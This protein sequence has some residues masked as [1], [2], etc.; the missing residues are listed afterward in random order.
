MSDDQLPAAPPSPEPTTPAPDP[1]HAILPKV[2]FFEELKRRNLGRV[3]TLYAAVGYLILEVVEVFAHLLHFPYWIGRS[4][5]LLMVVGFPVALLVAW[6]YEITPTGLKPTEEVSPRQSIRAETGKRLDRSIIAVLAIALC[7]LVV[8]KFWF[9]GSAVVEETAKPAERTKASTKVV[10]SSGAP[11]NIPAL[12]GVSDNSI[13]VLPFVNLSAETEQEYF[14]DGISEELLNRLAK[15]PGLRVISRS[16]AFS[17]KGKGAKIAQIASELNATH[18]LEGSVRK[19]GTQVRITAQLI[20]ARSDTNRWSETYD[21]PL[22]DIFAVQDEIATAIVAQFKTIMFQASGRVD[23]ATDPAAY[24]DYLRAKQL[25]RTGSK[26]T[27]EQATALL[28]Q[29]IAIDARYAPAWRLLSETYSQRSWL[30]FLP[31][32]EGFAKARAAIQQAI[33]IDPS[34]VATIAA[35]ADLV[36]HY[37]MNLPETARLVKRAL[38]LSPSHEAALSAAGNLTRATGDAKRSIAIAE[39]LVRRDPRNAAVWDSL[40]FTYMIFGRY[41][42][43]IAALRRSLELAPDGVFTHVVLG[44]ALLLAGDFDSALAEMQREPHDTMRPLGL[45]FAYAALGKGEEAQRLL[46]KVGREHPDFASLVAAGYARLRK[47]DEAFKW[48]DRALQERDGGI[49]ELRAGPWF[50][51]LGQDPRYVPLLQRIGLSDE[52][53]EALDFD[54]ELPQA[55]GAS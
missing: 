5:V 20:D 17:Y 10:A 46:E 4:V 14:S 7:Y 31:L 11:S 37:D 23:K 12:D 33:D 39:E 18:V 9:S 32:H 28:E 48:L 53:V 13:V 16:S 24:A 42:D 34:D 2:R 25:Y 45:A 41:A 27:L 35:L 19:S 38:S 36:Q 8:E 1:A 15:I 40:G 26:A 50:Q 21:R 47:P 30:G 29:A 51:T 22:D 44:E 3:A 52:Q 55:A 43:A 54:I 49:L 6:I